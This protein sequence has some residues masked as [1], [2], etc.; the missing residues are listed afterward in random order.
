MRILHT[1]DWHLGHTL[2]DQPRIEEHAAFLG[3]LLARINTRVDDAL[4]IAGDVFDSANPPTVALSM[5]YR[6]LAAARRL[7]P[8]LDI[9]VVGGNHDSAAR[10]DA[11]RPLLDA[12]Q[13]HMVGG[14]PRDGNGALDAQQLLCPLRDA[15]GAITA[16]VVALPYLRPSDLAAT[17]ADVVGGVRAL[18]AEAVALGRARLTP[19]QALVITG[20]CYMA[21]AALSEGSERKIQ[22]GNQSALPPDVFPNDAAY[23]ALGHLHF[24][25]A[26]G[27][28]HIRYAGS[29]IPLSMREL[30]YT[31][32]VVEVQL[33]GPRFV[34]A[35]AL[36]VPRVVDMIRVPADGAAPLAQ[37]LP[38]L[39]A[40]PLLEP[41]TPRW[42]RPFLAVRVHIDGPEPDLRRLVELALEGRTPRLVKLE[43][44]RTR[45]GRA[46]ADHHA[47]DL[48]TLLPEE[49][50]R[51]RWS[52]EHEGAPPDT[53]LAAFHELRER[54]AEES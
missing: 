1:G 27:V 15:S 5:F 40:L 37:V 3:W 25:Q 21:G 23:V 14:L 8:T 34:E 12:L 46:L 45:T 28:P 29:P 9:V 16:W 2:R 10:L 48:G 47:V 19:G 31:H 33:E 11:P 13:V 51:R 20:H 18:V 50:F 43:V 22:R 24:A 52:R 53:L 26:V 6:F 36:P 17:G 54:V 4:I 35:N 38:L 39:E 32:Q 41:G 42:R 30:N 7:H 49:V 44:R